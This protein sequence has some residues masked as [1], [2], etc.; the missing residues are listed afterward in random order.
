[1]ASTRESNLSSSTASSYTNSDINILKRLNKVSTEHVADIFDSL[2]IK[3]RVINS[4]TSGIK[5]IN[6]TSP[7]CGKA[8]TVEFSN[9]ADQR[10]AIGIN[11]RDYLNYVPEGSVI[12]I[13]NTAGNEFSVWGG[14]LSFYAN[15]HKIL[16]TITNGSARDIDDIQKQ[17]YPV[18]SSGASCNR[19]TGRYKVVALQST[20]TI[21][22]VNINPGDYVLASRS[23]IVVL[24]PLQ[25]DKI[26]SLAEKKRED[27][28]NVIK[29]I[30][31][32]YSLF[33]VDKKMAEDKKSLEVD[34]HHKTPGVI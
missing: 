31:L 17:P 6:Y 28:E 29:L 26:I 30:S 7:L 20:I 25:A 24:D 10:D 12:M 8:Y 18:F 1:M 32:G 34:H 27:E 22:G 4:S 9:L 11:T 14:I 15:Q 3:G 16:G 2:G 19:S 33:D 23:G 13:G 5:P 21:S